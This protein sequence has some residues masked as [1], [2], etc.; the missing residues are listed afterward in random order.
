VQEAGITE[1]I[2]SCLAEEPEEQRR[3]A[4]WGGGRIYRKMAMRTKVVEWRLKDVTNT[5]DESKR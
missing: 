2:E 3:E 4:W 5:N 1:Y